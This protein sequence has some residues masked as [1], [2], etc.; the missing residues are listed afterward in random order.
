MSK[1]YTREINT[2]T[3]VLSN[4]GYAAM[5]IVGIWLGI[6]QGIERGISRAAL[7]YDSLLWDLSSHNGDL[8]Y[9]L[10]PYTHWVDILIGLGIA[11]GVAAVG[12]V[13]IWALTLPFSK[14]VAK[15]A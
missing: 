9:S 10:E 15:N 6:Q 5:V 12:C 14:K 11:A 2:V 13:A 7:G 3:R 4:I 8:Y 1:G